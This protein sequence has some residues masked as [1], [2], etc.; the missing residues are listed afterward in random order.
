M[1][2]LSFGELACDQQDSCCHAWATEL[3]GHQL[4]LCG[5]LLNLGS[6]EDDEFGCIESTL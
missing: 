3:L 2:A 6:P 1:E 5:R 4:V